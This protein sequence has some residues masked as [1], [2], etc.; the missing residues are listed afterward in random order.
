MRPFALSL[1]LCVGLAG[2]GGFVPPADAQSAATAVASGAF[3]DISPRYDGSGTATIAETADGQSVLQLG[4]FSVT[5]GPD[6]EVW[7]VAADAPTTNNAVLA[8][9]YVSLGALQSPTGTQTYAIPS[10][11]DISD[12]GSVVIWCED[13]SVLFTM[14]SFR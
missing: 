11:V 6:L 10:N 14:A 4:D 3:Q 13:F 12:Y 1:A 9:T 7:L 2:L 5:P 8:S